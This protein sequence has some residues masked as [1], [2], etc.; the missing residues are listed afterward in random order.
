[1]TV[2][3]NKAV[4][5]HETDLGF[6]DFAGTCVPLVG[7]GVAEGPVGFELAFFCGDFARCLVWDCF[8]KG[9]GSP[10]CLNGKSVTLQFCQKNENRR[11]KKKRPTVESPFLGFLA[12]RGKTINLSLYAF[13]LS[14]LTSFPSSLKFLLL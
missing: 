7:T 3:T 1:M 12:L 11:D 6:P 8:G 9:E 5:G 4:N 10:C 2:S 13:S 14:T